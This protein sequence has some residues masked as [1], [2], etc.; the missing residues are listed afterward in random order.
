M[1][2]PL[3]R[4][5]YSVRFTASEALVGKLERLGALLSHTSAPSDLPGLLEQAVDLAIAHHEKRRFGAKTKRRSRKA[6]ANPRHIP[7]PVRRAVFERD[8]G[9]CTFEAPDGRRCDSRHRSNS[10]TSCLSPWAVRAPPTTCASDARRTTCSKPDGA[11]V[12][13][14]LNV[15]WGSPADCVVAAPSRVA[16]VQHPESEPPRSTRL[17]SPANTARRRAQGGSR[18]PAHG[19]SPTNGSVLSGLLTRPSTSTDLAGR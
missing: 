3:G 18:G 13:A 7:A 17:P 16:T 10:T 8:Q 12:R 6:S 15:L 1:T 14:T 2:T 11:S 9:R 5:R 19:E 4:A